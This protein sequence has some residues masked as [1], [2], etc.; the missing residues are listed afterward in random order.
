VIF[1][2]PKRNTAPLKIKEKLGL[3]PIGEEVINWPALIEP[4]LVKVFRAT[5]TELLLLKA[6]VGL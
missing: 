3:E 4:L 5:L 1:K 6:R 2:T